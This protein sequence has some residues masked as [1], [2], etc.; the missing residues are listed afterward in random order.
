V[1][2]TL[3]VAVVPVADVDRAKNP[4]LDWA[5]WYAQYMVQEQAGHPAQAR[6]GAST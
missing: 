3:E 5:G 1:D 6:P 2:M 4:D